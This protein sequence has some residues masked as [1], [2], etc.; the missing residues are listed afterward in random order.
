MA[1]QPFWPSGRLIS[2]RPC[3]S[4]SEL[5]RLVIWIEGEW[6]TQSK[7]DDAGSLET[8]SASHRR[9]G[10]RHIWLGGGGLCGAQ[11]EGGEVAR[12]VESR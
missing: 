1:L 3:W 11:V 5:A 4:G 6:G 8:L 10:V 2:D 12:R 9:V 7:D